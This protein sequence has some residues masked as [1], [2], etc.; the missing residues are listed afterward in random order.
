MARDTN[1]P[2]QYQIMAQKLS[3]QAPLSNQPYQNIS[4]PYQ[5]GSSLYRAYDQS[6]YGAGHPYGPQVDQRERYRKQEEEKNRIKREQKKQGQKQLTG[7]VAGGLSSALALYLGDKAARGL[8][9]AG[10]GTATQ[11]GTQTGTQVGTQT[12]AGAGAGTVAGEGA[13]TGAGTATGAGVTAETGAATGAGATAEGA[14]ATTAQGAG[15][16]GAGSGS[17]LG[18]YAGSAGIAA[19]IAK[20][21]DSAMN[22]AAYRKRGGPGLTQSEIQAS[23]GHGGVDKQVKKI[24]RQLE[25]LPGSP[26][27]VRTNPVN[28]L[29]RALLGSTKNDDQ[30]RRDRVREKLQKGKAIDENFAFTLSDGTKYDIGNEGDDD[31]IVNASGEGTHRNYNVDTTNSLAAQAVGWANPL[32]R[33]VSGGDKKLTSDFAGYLANA[34]MSN[35]NGDPE[36]VRANLNKIMT[37]MGF[38]PTDV[39]AGLEALKQSLDEKQMTQEEYDAAVYGLHTLANGMPEGQTYAQNPQTGGNG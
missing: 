4:G 7:Q 27:I 18:G 17:S 37:D 14:G 29:T 28:I 16:A 32:A 39:L 24:D 36:V 20:G 30:I 12:G 8:F 25:K 19:G 34:A 1:V 15:T 9:S 35:A 6:G 2:L 21:I 11:T 38:T 31:K 10:A 3:G 33:I 26:G 22:L 13:A 23:Y 5:Q